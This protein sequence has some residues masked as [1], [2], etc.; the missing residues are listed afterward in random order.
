MGELS[1]ERKHNGKP[2]KGKN[3]PCG[4]LLQRYMRGKKALAIYCP[5]LYN[6]NGKTGQK[7]E[8]G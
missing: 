1:E 8:T 6:K 7:S 4:I 5:A 2:G 3:A